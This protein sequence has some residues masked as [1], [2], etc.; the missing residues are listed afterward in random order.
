[1]NYTFAP[2]SS[3]AQKGIIPAMKLPAASYG[4]GTLFL[5]H[6]TDSVSFDIDIQQN[7][8]T[9]DSSLMRQFYLTENKSYLEL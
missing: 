6:N 9:F 1:M 8:R 5:I 2:L 4:E 3:K 7:C